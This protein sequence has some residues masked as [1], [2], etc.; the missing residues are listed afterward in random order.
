MSIAC[1]IAKQLEQLDTQ[2]NF[3]WYIKEVERML[4]LF[5]SNKEEMLHHSNIFQMLL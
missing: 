1:D 3:S 5:H 4:K 2:V